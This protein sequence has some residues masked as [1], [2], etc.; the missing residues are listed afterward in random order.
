MVDKSILPSADVVRIYICDATC[1]L[2]YKL[3]FLT[4]D[5]I[6]H[7]VKVHVSV[8]YVDVFALRTISKRI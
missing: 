6:L 5:E 3:V 4:V 2:R 1:V 8:S 7:L